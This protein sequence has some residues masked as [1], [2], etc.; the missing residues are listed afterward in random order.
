MHQLGQWDSHGAALAADLDPQRPAERLPLQHPQ[1]YP[2]PHAQAGQ[3]LQGGAV[4]VTDPVHPEKLTHGHAGERG[5]PVLDVVRRGLR[6]RV[7]V[8]IPPRMP[9]R[10]VDPFDQQVAGGVLQ[11]F[12]LVMHLIPAH[13]GGLHQ[14]SL[15][16]PVPPDHIP[17]M[18]LAV[19]AQHDA[20]AARCGQQARRAEPVQH[21]RYR[22]RS[23]SQPGRH[24]RG[25]DRRGLEG[26]EI[27][28]PQVFPHR[29]R[30]RRCTTRGPAPADT[31]IMRSA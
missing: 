28:D 9:Q 17:G 22:G 15:D 2:R 4:L 19:L 30:T 14:E 21:R 6:N 25:Q 13:P 3:I 18:P 27:D 12:G 20:T 7:A 24:I 5:R 16:Q 23:N 10:R 11:R 1:H 29:L 31:S 8:R 26:Q